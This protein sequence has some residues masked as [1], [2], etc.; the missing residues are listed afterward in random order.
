MNR[1]FDLSRLCWYATEYIIFNSHIFHIICLKVSLPRLQIVKVYNLSGLLRGF[2]NMQ[3][4]T[5]V[6]K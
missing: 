3:N 2:Y 6:I 4:K 5:A 1:L